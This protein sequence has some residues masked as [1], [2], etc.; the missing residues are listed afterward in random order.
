METTYKQYVISD[1]PSKIQ[2]ETV[3]EFLAGS[4]WA[5]L[6]Q[7]ERIRASIRSSVCYGVYDG[8]RMVGFARVVTDGAAVY[9]VCDVFVLEAYRGQGISK[10]LVELIT[11]APE[12]EW[13]TGILGTRDAHGL[14]EQF[15]FQR[16]AQAY[17]KRLP[18]A[19]RG[20]GE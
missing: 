13:M 7:P 5:N 17:M 19:R 16:D 18:Q 6:R 4:Y 8:D 2:V 11:N 20:E 3:V 14:Y 1:D 12:F 10:K 9:Y 15:G